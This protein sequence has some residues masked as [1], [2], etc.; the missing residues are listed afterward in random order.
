MGRLFVADVAKGENNED[1]RR[2][3]GADCI[4][5][6]Q[7]DGEGKADKEC[8]HCV[9]RCV[10]CLLC[11]YIGSIE[12]NKPQR[13]NVIESGRLTTQEHLARGKAGMCVAPLTR[14]LTERSVIVGCSAKKRANQP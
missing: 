9:G 14:E 3:T 4:G 6:L 8:G 11:V 10:Y 7:R 12:R 1:S 13:G 5:M 2:R